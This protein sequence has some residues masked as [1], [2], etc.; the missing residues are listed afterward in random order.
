MRT[1]ML[2]EEQ[3]QDLLILA[4]GEGGLAGARP[5]YTNDM[6]A[7]AST[8]IF[9][10]EA[11]GIK[12]SVSVYALGL[13]VA[14]GAD[15]PARAAFMKLAE[16]LADFDQGG[17]IETAVYEPAAYRGVLFESPGIV[18]PDVRA[19][20]WTDISPADFAID[21]D[22]NGNQ[23]PHRVMTPAEVELLDVADYQ[24]GF[25]NLVLNGSDGKEYTFSLR[26]LLP[27]EE[28]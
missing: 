8:A 4:L 3:I 22:P 13:D 18:A 14:G 17:S 27:G 6:V 7:D 5:N 11:G 20:P 28:K 12:K 15:A 25:Q 24:G 10:I 9:T 21:A 19:W 26:P 16:R 23:F 1:A 2:S